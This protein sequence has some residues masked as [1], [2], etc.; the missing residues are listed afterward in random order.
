[1]NMNRS[2]LR[3]R[4]YWLTSALSLAALQPLGA[5]TASPA[6]EST[7]APDADVIELSPFIVEAS[8]DSGYAAKDTL[9]GTRVRTELKDVASALTVV[10][11]Q[12]LRDT[13]AKNSQDLLVYTTNTE[14]GGIYGNYSGMGGSPTFNE[15]ANLLRPSNNTRVRGLDS[16][17][18]TRDYFLTEIPWDGYNVGRVDLQ[19]GP[20]SILFGVGSPAGII[21]TS[22]NTAGFRN[23]NSVENRFGQYGSLRFSGDFNYVVKKDV[24]AIR[25]SFLDDKTKYQQE[26]AYNHD[27]RLYG[28]LRFEPKLF[29]KGN[30]TSLRLNYEDGKVDANRPRSLP[31]IDAITPWFKS[32]GNGLNKLTLNPNTSWNQ[33]GNNPAIPGFFDPRL[34]VMGRSFSSNIAGYY[35][36]NNSTPLLVR[37]PNLNTSRG[38]DGNGNIDGTIGGFEFS[39]PWGIATYNAYARSAIP[40]GKYYS[41]VSLSDPTIFDFYNKLIDGDNKNEWQDWR[42]FNGALSQT[43]L[44]DRVGLEIAYDAQRYNDGQV[45]FLGGDQYSISIDINNTLIG[46][47]ANPNVG[48]P[49]VSNSGQYGNTENHIDR[50]SVRLTAFGEIRASDFLNEEGFL[51]RLL[52]RHLFTGLLSQDTKRTD[53]RGYS[54]WASGT[55]FTSYTGQIADIT[56]GARQVDWTAYLGPSLAGAG[57]ASGAYLSAV[58][59]RINPTGTAA[60]TFFNSQWN[61]PTVDAA[62]PYT[63]ITHDSSGNPVSTT[64]IQA[65]NPANYVGW[66]TANFSVL[67]AENGDIES[68]YSSG[69]KSKNKIKSTGFTWQAHL[70]DDVIVPTFGWRKDVVTNSSSQAP[71]NAQQV[72][73][74]DYDVDTSDANTQRAE[75]ISRTWGVVVHTPKAWRNKLPGGTHFSL[76][77]NRGENFKADAPRGDIFGNIIPNPNGRTK[78]F[79]VVISTL[80]DRVSLKINKYET[81]VQ[82]ASLQADSAGFSSS[83]YYVWALPYWGA[84][85]ALAAQDGIS[86][87]QLRQGNWGWPWNGIATLPDGSPDNARIGA[88]VKDFFTKFP[89]DQNFADQYGLGMNIA[90]MHS[91]N[92][93]DW[94]ASIPTYGVNGQGAS[95]LG[96]QPAYGGNLKSTGSGPVAAV[97]TTSKG[98]EYE[99]YAQMNKNWS[100]T[101]NVSK[102]DASRTAISPTIAAFIGTYTTFLAGDAGL[103]KL[104]GGD[105]IRKVWADNVLAPYS[106][107]QGQIGSSAPEIAKWHWNVVSNYNFDSGPLKNVNVG[108]AYRWEDKRILGYKYNATTDTLDITQ[109]WFGPTEDHF[110][111]WV[112]YHRPIT[113]RVNWRV[114][115]N[116]RNVGESAHLSPVNIQPDGTVALSRIQQGMSWQ[117]TNTFSF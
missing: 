48:R 68:L 16:A 117:L 65:D 39:R 22:L 34:G 109:P 1:M 12:F 20:N 80:N 61:A 104:W 89:L 14:V 42:A 25:A 99:L 54:R 72:S 7:P 64:G 50:D 67:G 103:I 35:D 101:L 38:I 97:D 37:T 49:Y 91:N 85:H 31:P 86:D 94:Y 88:I 98:M 111:F 87:P 45:A 106:V 40:G 66:Q 105:P 10:T 70:L 3:L 110:D 18:N 41:N 33:Y 100:V 59:A 23:A 74:M 115:L 60:L 30:N 116:L 102:T 113:K 79:G 27:Q 73:L 5:Q 107:L 108:G 46:G 112:G 47:G 57:S 63:Y 51:A 58:N 9:A 78:D 6:P 24:L 84:T 71:K 21:N 2:S 26:P 90:K 76:F 92:V 83:L 75:G 77:Y 13:G 82:N 69:Q 93:A 11:S 56:N 55:D 29:G 95:A 43:F 114:Q 53:Y 81:S 36:A 96:L 62:A 28:A 8:E 19:R 17:D 44:N 52:G 4:A 32:G 15:S